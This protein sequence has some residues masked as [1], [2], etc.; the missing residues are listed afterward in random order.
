MCVGGWENSV[1]K[2]S[3]IG[4]NFLFDNFIYNAGKS[5]TFFQI[6]KTTIYVVKAEK[7][8]SKTYFYHHSHSGV[9]RNKSI[10][11]TWVFGDYAINS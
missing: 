4:M 10:S 8:F 2:A 11:L 6:L 9:K 5:N 1:S 7:L 3:M